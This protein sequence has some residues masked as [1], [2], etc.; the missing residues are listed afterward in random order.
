MKRVHGMNLYASESD[1]FLSGIWPSCLQELFSF[2]FDYLNIFKARENNSLYA[3]FVRENLANHAM[4][5]LRECGPD[6]S[7][8][9]PPRGSNGVGPVSFQSDVEQDIGVASG[10]KLTCAKNLSGYPNACSGYF[11]ATLAWDKRQEGNFA[12]QKTMHYGMGLY[13]FTTYQASTEQARHVVEV[14][15]S[16]GEVDG[17]CGT[18]YEVKTTTSSCFGLNVIRLPPPVD[19]PKPPGLSDLVKPALPRLHATFAGMRTGPVLAIGLLIVLVMYGVGAGARYLLC[20]RQ[21]EEQALHTAREV[22]LS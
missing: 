18:E 15:F 22:E 14:R 20:K 8:C 12:H 7:K 21:Q 17:I 9:P 19:P 16:M 3:L 2:A 11:N 10:V 1:S 13:F 6:G 4:A 5:K